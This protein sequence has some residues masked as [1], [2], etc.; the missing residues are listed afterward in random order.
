MPQIWHISMREEQRAIIMTKQEMLKAMCLE[1]G[2]ADLKAIGQSRGFDPQTIASRA[3]LE[4]VFLSEQGLTAAL[5][6]LTEAET[7]GL[8]LLNCLGEAVDLDFFKRVYPGLVPGGYY[9]SFTESHKG[10]FQKVKAQLVRRGILLCGILPKGY[11]NL[12]V[13]ERT[14]LVF[15]EEFASFL[16]ALFRPRQ[17][18]PTAAGQHRGNILRNKLR[19]ISQMEAAPSGAAA[20]S[21]TG[22]WR[23]AKGELLF[24]GKPFRVKQLEAWRLA[25]FEAS[26]A[27]KARE[28]AEALQPVPLLRYAFSRLRE[29]EWL[30][31]EELMAFWNMALPAT[32]A[33]APLTVC[34]AG[35]EWGCFERIEQEGGFLYRLPHPPDAVA[36]TSPEDF[37]DAGDV[38]AVRL[39]LDRAPLEALEQ[40]AEVSRLKV[41]QGALWAQPDLLKL[42]H[43]SADTLAG[44]MF[45]WLRERHPAFRRT[46]ETIELRRG[47]LIV[48]QNLLVAR[49]SDLSLKVM[50]EKKFGQPGQLVSLSREFVAFP[51]GLLP[52]IKAWLKK[53]GHVVKSIDS[54]ETSAEDSET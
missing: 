39:D 41:A 36:E 28:Q 23:L 11:E 30:A 7:L 10:L 14:R 8:H 16:P 53:S 17:L 46:S 44:P 54:Y 15:P 12:S 9:Q 50:L 38:G 34:E 24:G 37:L 31:P 5:A 40:V 35:Y 45:H 29:N 2:Q 18:D 49:V 33:P 25:Q 52:E 22:R 6:S 51:N 21:E 48:H 27:Y 42:S 26:V 1:L 20:R 4:H 43:A 32:K 19:E 13:L 47:K 3:L